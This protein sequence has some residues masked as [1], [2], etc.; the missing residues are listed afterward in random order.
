[1]THSD[2]ASQAHDMTR[3][4]IATGMA[5]D[6][7]RARSKNGRVKWSVDRVSSSSPCGTT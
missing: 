5:F 4:D 6:K 3:L 1:M 7:R 2:F